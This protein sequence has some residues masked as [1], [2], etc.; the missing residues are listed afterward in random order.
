MRPDEAVLLTRFVKA[1][2]PSQQIDEYTPDAW[3][4]SLD[5]IPLDIAK[6]AVSEVAKT[7]RFIAVSEIRAAVSRM[8]AI[9]RVS[10]RAVV[11]EVPFAGD[12]DDIRGWLDHGRAE[13]ARLDALAD[14]V[15]RN[16]AIDFSGTDVLAE[17]NADD[18]YSSAAALPIDTT[19]L[20][21]A[22]PSR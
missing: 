22:I 2:F 14:D 13:R 15:I 6:M 18:F 10:V 19:K 4:M 8:R 11:A 9:A 5:D 17:S 21:L 20:P 7:H 16:R 3:G 1:M 12:P